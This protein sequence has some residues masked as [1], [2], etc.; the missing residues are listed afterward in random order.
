MIAS[1]YQMSKEL[2]LWYG[3]V[4]LLAVFIILTV[5]VGIRNSLGVFFKDI[6]GEFGWNRA[7]TGAAFTMGM[8]GRG[9]WPHS[10]AGCS[11]AS[12]CAG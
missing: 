8:L 11:S 2:R 12:T 4:I 1:R 7:Q 9:W 5:T 3:W 6:S 10:R